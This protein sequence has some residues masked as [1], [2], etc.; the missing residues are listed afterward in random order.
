VLVTLTGTGGCG[1]TQLSLLVATGLIESFPDG[2]WLV[3]MA[4][5]QTPQLVAQTVISARVSNPTSP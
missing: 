4:P 5:V 1:K 2:V 3:D